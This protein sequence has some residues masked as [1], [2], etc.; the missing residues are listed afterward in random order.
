MLACM[1]S[2]SFGEYVVV[3]HLHLEREYVN[4]HNSRCLEKLG[5]LYENT[6]MS[7][8]VNTTHQTV[9]L[10]RRDIRTRLA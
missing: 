9:L 5:Q 6:E 2:C 3:R 1:V 10:L 7:G 8:L 4:F